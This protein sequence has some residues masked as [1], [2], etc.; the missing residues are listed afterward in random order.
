MRR[1]CD[2]LVIGL[3]DL[4]LR[5]FA[6]KGLEFGVTN[7]QRQIMFP[8]KQRCWYFR[9]SRR[10]FYLTQTIQVLGTVYL[11]PFAIEITQM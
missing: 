2:R 6:F 10:Q 8:H 7:Q 3:N 1:F 9:D 4:N 5:V 11:P